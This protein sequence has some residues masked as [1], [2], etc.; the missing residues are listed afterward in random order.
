VE[1]SDGHL[2]SVASL[3][4]LKSFSTHRVDARTVLNIDSG[5]EK[6][7]KIFQGTSI[8]RGSVTPIS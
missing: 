5:E 6:N 3:P 8:V 7:P 2:H 4:L 1:R